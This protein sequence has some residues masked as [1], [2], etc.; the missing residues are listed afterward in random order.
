LL[1][2][3]LKMVFGEFSAGAGFEVSFKRGRF[4]FLSEGNGGFETPGLV[5]ACVGDFPGIVRGKASLQIVCETYV[6]VV[7]V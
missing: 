5:F 6:V 7:G 2:C 3:E 1:R 4:G